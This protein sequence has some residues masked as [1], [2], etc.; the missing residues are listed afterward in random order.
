MYILFTPSITHPQ[1]SQQKL[2]LLEVVKVLQN[3]YQY[4]FT[5]ANDV[6]ENVYVNPVPKGLTFKKIIQYLQKETKLVFRFLDNNFIAI[7]QKREALSICGYVL[8]QDTGNPLLGVTVVANSNATVTDEFGYFYLV[9]FNKNDN[10]NLRFL[11]YQTIL[12]NATNFFL[13]DGCTYIP[14]IPQ[15]ETLTEITLTN[16]LTKGMTKLADGTFDIDF[17][18]FGILPGLIETDVLQTIQ[19]F[20]G[21]LSVSETVSDINIRGGTNDQ[22][23]ILWDGIKMYQS[24]HFFGLIS[25]F[26]PQM[27]KNAKLIKNGTSAEFSDGVSGTIAMNTDTNLNTVTTGSVG[28]NLINVDGFVDIPFG[29]TS[30]I[31]VSA[32]KAINDFVDTPTYSRYF[33]RITQDSEVLSSQNQRQNFDFYDLSFRWLYRITEKDLLRV[34]GILVNNELLFN[35]KITRNNVEE[36][37]ES[38]LAQETLAAGLY[39]KRKWN[40]YFVSELTATESRYDLTAQNV[41]LLNQLTLNQQNTVSETSI[42]LNTFYKPN[43]Q[44][45]FLNGYQLTE[46]GITNLVDVD[47]PPFNSKILEVIRE[48]SLYSEI[49]FKTESNKTNFKAGVRYNYIDLINKNAHVI[50][51]R[52]SINHKLTDELTLD[53]LGEF[54]HQNSSQIIIG[55]NDFLGIEKR[56]W[57]LSN[58]DTIPIVKSKQISTGINYTKKGWY[59]GAEGFLKEVKGITSQSQGFLTDKAS[60]KVNGSYF[61]KGID[62][63]INKRFRKISTW[64][65]YSLADNQYTFNEFEEVNFPNNIDI[66]HSLSLGTS[67]VTDKLKISAGLNWHKGRPTT[68]PNLEDEIADNTINYKPENSS[69]VSRYLRIDTSAIYNFNLAPKIKARAGVSVWNVLNNNNVINEYYLLNDSNINKISNSALE[70]TPNFTFKVDF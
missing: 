1:K 53:V 57:Q 33:E 64:F 24:G 48:H 18:N 65:S 37:K 63:L 27:T 47:N 15:I 3:D 20:P 28:F 22:N 17:T 16:Y 11:G 46:T 54:K 7:N 55:Q 32:R 67:Y 30:S 40:D 42:K 23:L 51:P 12:M 26:N 61:V 31:Q 60:I 39:Y 10:I 41:D 34:S 25:I 38:N 45:A 59:V 14:L 9:I 36:S 4:T 70:F 49:S 2:P 13:N 50:E 52:L 69:N 44:L 6:I 19:S 56:R 43:W 68:R 5:Y 66:K 58:I 62:L 29:E 35:E 21:I 8:D